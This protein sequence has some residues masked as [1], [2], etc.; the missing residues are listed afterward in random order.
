MKL[1]VKLLAVLL[2]TALLCCSCA[3]GVPELP[4][5]TP[6]GSVLPENSLPPEGSATPAPEEQECSGLLTV[7]DGSHYAL[8][9][10]QGEQLSGFDY[11]YI[12]LME[13]YVLYSRLTTEADGLP[14][15]VTSLYAIGST[16][17]ELLTGFLYSGRLNLVAGG[18]AEGAPVLESLLR[19]GTGDGSPRSE[20]TVLLDAHTG[21]ELLTLPSDEFSY[22]C[23]QRD[24]GLVCSMSYSTQSLSVWRVSDLIAGSQEPLARLE[25]VTGMDYNSEA[26]IVTVSSL[27]DENGETR[28]QVLLSDGTLSEN[29][30]AS[31]SSFYDLP[32]CAVAQAEPG[33][34]CGLIDQNGE[35]LIPPQY[36]ALT[37]S[38]NG[39]CVVLANGVYSYV[40]KSGNTVLPGPYLQAE[41]F[42]DGFASVTAMDGAVQLIDE[43]GR[44]VVNEE[45]FGY[46]GFTTGAA[47]EVS[48]GDYVFNEEARPAILTQDGKLYELPAE[49]YNPYVICT[50][51]DRCFFTY[52]ADTEHY[53]SAVGVLD[54]ATGEASAWQEGY[55]YLSVLY[56]TNFEPLKSGYLRASRSLKNGYTVYDLL[57]ADG[58]QVL[59]SNLNEIYNATPN[60]MAVK[61]GF[62]CGVM[63]YEG[64]WLYKTTVFNS[65]PIAD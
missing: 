16:E 35:W 53:E 33:G 43:S 52:T 27:P 65:F 28:Q 7:Y 10:D 48:L 5:G 25:G 56:D 41:T 31:I 26:N 3:P 44:V 38:E 20:D 30:F 12:N 63:D 19:A 60:A 54:F 42:R 47:V 49:F 32:G 15:E 2:F 57:S 45:V 13:G 22:F 61:K 40:D 17:G 6:N 14:E 23:Y 24:R 11:N 62:S 8:F 34:A 55:R 36:D 59:V 51:P 4:S 64:N 21:A 50:L 39:L 1:G 29:S 58:S 46:Y 18:E 37:P 9:T